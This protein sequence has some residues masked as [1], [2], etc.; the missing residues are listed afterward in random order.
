V[1]R[2]VVVTRTRYKL[3]ASRAETSFEIALKLGAIEVFTDED[4]LGRPLFILLPRAIRHAFK[5][6]VYAL[7]NVTFV[8]TLNGE[9]ALHAV[10]VFPTLVEEKTEPV[11][12]EIEIEVALE[13]E[14]DAADGVIVD[15]VR[16]RVAV[17]A[18]DFAFAVSAVR[19]RV[20]VFLLSV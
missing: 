17:F 7:E 4:E 13:G 15:V 14:G 18:A 5:E 1:K 6:G 20:R 8:A 3:L 19:V 2:A 10:E 12:D 11:V 9:H 16:M